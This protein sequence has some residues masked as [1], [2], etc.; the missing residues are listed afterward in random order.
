MTP[1]GTQSHIT[2]VPLGGAY[3]IAVR[4]E[5]NDVNEQYSQRL[6]PGWNEIIGD[7]FIPQV[8]W[9][10]GMYTF[11]VEIILEP[12]EVLASFTMEHFLEGEL[13][14]SN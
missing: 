5:A 8:F 3:H 12:D 13:S 11:D 9:Y 6:K 7:T 14:L 4:Q 10:P 1:N 2:V